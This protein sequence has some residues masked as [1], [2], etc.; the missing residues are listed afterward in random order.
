MAQILQ[1][2]QIWLK[3]HRATFVSNSFWHCLFWRAEVFNV[4]LR[5]SAAEHCFAFQWDIYGSTF[6]TEFLV[7]DDE[8]SALLASA[9]DA[10][11]DFYRP[12]NSYI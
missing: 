10:R 5:L 1:G 6:L 7:R 3:L 4:L 2:C 11:S 12:T 9:V 8:R